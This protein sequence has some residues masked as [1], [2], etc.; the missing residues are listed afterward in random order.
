MVA[1]TPTP[2]FTREADRIYSGAQ[3]D[4]L[5][6]RHSDAYESRAATVSLSFSL[7]RLPGEM[8][9]ISKDGKGAGKGD[10]TLWVKDGTLLLSQSD[11]ADTEYLKVPDLVLSAQTKYHIS[12]SFGSDGLMIWL[13][14]ALVAA[15]P[16]FKQGLKLND[17][18]L[19]VGGS[20]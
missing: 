14:G 13:N 16:E 15:E 2:V 3:E 1:N 12:V 5:N 10:F 7:D 4:I 11:G 17:H 18:S 6:I 20:R 8:A 9:L 19:V